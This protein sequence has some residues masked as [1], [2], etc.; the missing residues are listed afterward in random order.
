M[1]GGKMDPDKYVDPAISA[2]D[3]SGGFFE[4]AGC[5]S[6]ILLLAALL[7]IAVESW[8]ILVKPEVSGQV[9]L[10]ETVH[11]KGS[12]Y[13]F[14]KV[15]GNEYPLYLPSRIFKRIKEGDF[16][17]KKSH[18]IFFKHIDSFFTLLPLCHLAF[19]FLSPA[20]MVIWKF[21]DSKIGIIFS[22]LYAERPILVM[23]AL[24][25]IYGF[26]II[27]GFYE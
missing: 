19:L 7:F 13:N 9:V 20:G 3:Q 8:V 21:R 1:V 5:T 4:K 22:N 17:E 25:G 10:K 2:Y 16:V 27:M 24:S 15:S 11:R 26:L 23:T 18:S 6:I 12:E 14:V